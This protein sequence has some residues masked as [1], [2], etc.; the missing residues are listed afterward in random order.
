MFHRNMPL[1]QAFR[2]KHKLM[3]D[4]NER[5]TLDASAPSTPFDGV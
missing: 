4:S 2:V 3:N 1:N 5:F